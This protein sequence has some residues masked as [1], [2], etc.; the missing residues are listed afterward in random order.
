MAQAD[1]R[2][3]AVLGIGG[4][5]LIQNLLVPPRAYVPAN[6]V[7]GLG[8]FALARRHGCTW[9]DLGL[10][11]T[12][13]PDGFRLG[14]AGV[15]MAAAV[16]VGAGA[17]PKTRRY[18][19]DE[20]AAGQRPNDVVFRTMVR[21]PLGTA[22]FEELAFRGVIY[23]MWRRSG[24][25][26]PQAAAVTAGTFVVWHLIP[27]RQA[28]AGNPLGPRLGGPRSRATV[29]LTGAVLTGVSSL[30][31]SWMRERSGSLIAPWMTHAAF[32]SALY[33]AG[34]AAWRRATNR[35]GRFDS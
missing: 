32:N 1:R 33:L 21:F 17:F 18:L 7:A 15:A 11:P 26:S 30:G 9:E 20:R 22:L 31:L 5:N 24:A 16:A 12:Q 14:T 29:V 23:G 4:Y 8:L 13:A 2:M 35:P 25:S 34:V 28:L 6:L 19:L 27:A 3:A 10:E